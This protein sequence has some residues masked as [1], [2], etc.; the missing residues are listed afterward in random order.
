MSSIEQT[1]RLIR[2]GLRRVAPQTFWFSIGF[3]VFNVIIG[4]A[5]FKAV[6][7]TTFTV[8]GVIPLRGWAF[9]FLLHGLFMLGSLVVNNWKVTRW[10]HYIGVGIKTAWW[11]ELLSVTLVG[12]SP[13]LLVIWSLLIYLQLVVCVHFTP[14]LGR[15]R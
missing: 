2:P 14:R 9:V 11:L 1:I 4:L 15:D 8:V 3:G 6:I 7:L 5:L 10:L 12:R 13:F